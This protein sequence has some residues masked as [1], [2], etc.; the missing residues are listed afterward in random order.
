MD[1]ISPIWTIFSS[2]L[3]WDE[4]ESTGPLFGLLYQPRMIMNVEHSVELQLAG[5]PKYSEKTCPNAT[6]ST[7]NPTWPDPGSHPRFRGGK[8][9]TNRL[10]YGTATYGP[11]NMSTS[12]GISRQT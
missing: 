2:F 5:E 3:G 10:S 11:L 12:T 4:A 8:R 9:T 7:T 6:L 1:C